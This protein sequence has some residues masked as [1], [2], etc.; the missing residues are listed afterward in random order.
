MIDTIKKEQMKL[1]E[2][3]AQ[4]HTPIIPALGRQRQV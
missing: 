3:W 1:L 2:I 4:W